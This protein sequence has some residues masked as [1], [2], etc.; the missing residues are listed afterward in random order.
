MTST[1][2]SGH[3]SDP[4]GQLTSLR[5]ALEV[6]LAGSLN[7]R[8][9]FDGATSLL[10]KYNP[11]EFPELLRPCFERIMKSRIAVRRKY[12]SATLFE[13]SRLTNSERR[14]LQKD[15]I[16]L[17]EACLLDIGR[18]SGTSSGVDRDYYDIVYPREDQKRSPEKRTRRRPQ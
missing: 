10:V 13:F 9:R 4:I 1:P 8:E 14:A 5:E 18:M 7:P 17:Y 6:L 3:W 12:V 11:R 2:A 16:A 15:V